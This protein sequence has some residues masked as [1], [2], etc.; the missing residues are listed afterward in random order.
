MASKISKRRST[1]TLD[2]TK[3]IKYTH[4]AFRSLWICGDPMD[5]C[6]SGETKTTHLWGFFYLQKQDE[7]T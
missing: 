1:S 4:L 5:E 3:E 2:M 7:D 6:D